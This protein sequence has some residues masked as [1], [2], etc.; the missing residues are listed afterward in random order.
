L[1]GIMAAKRTAELIPLC[2]PLP[3]TKVE[4]RIDID[5]ALPGFRVA[6]EVRTDAVTGVEMEALTAVSIACLTLFDMLKGIDRT[7]VI[8]GIE[9]ASKSGGKSGDWPSR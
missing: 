5:D 7:M 1:A 9:V 6:A 8:G 3:L 2:H 4:V